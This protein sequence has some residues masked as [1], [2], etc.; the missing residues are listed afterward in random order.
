MILMNKINLAHR[1]LL[2]ALADTSADGR[3]AVKLAQRRQPTV[4]EDIARIARAIGIDVRDI[5]NK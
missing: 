2:Q 3:R 1:T 5:V 4:A